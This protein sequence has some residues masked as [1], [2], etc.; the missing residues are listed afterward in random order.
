MPGK[1]Y[2][3]V[4]IFDK[5]EAET[6]LDA[7]ERYRTLH[8]ECTGVALTYAGRLDPMASGA[9]IVLSGEECKRRESYTS[10]DKEYDF[11]VLFGV[12]S[13]T[14]DILGIARQGA[15]ADDADAP[16]LIAERICGVHEWEYPA[17]SSKT[18]AGKPLWRHALEGSINAIEIPKR[19]MR[20]D[21][22]AYL[23]DRECT[24]AELFADST[25]RIEPL[26][27]GAFNDFRKD[28]VLASW[29]SLTNARYRIAS[30]RARVGSGTY[31]RRLA[32]EIGARAGSSALAYRIRRTR[33][34]DLP[35]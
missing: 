27:A 24:R 19:R 9:L 8:P 13:D 11:D 28:A 5:R 31:I 22:C 29:R 7:L 35:L 26:G 6:T 12:E 10:L 15:V 34:F 23:S 25:S 30:Y 3:V 18:V 2:R 33:F 32:Q 4:A 14:G 21:S 17:F 20:I 16:R 1:V